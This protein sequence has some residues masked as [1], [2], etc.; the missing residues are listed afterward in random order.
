[1]GQPGKAAGLGEAPEQLYHGMG[2]SSPGTVHPERLAAV[3]LPLAMERWGAW[4]SLLL[5]SGCITQ[6]PARP[7][8]LQH[9]HGHHGSSF[10]P[11]CDGDGL[12]L[13]EFV[14]K[15]ELAIHLV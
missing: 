10:L 13:T 7:G 5:S 12:C 15:S 11:H 4:V 8:P 1:M 14:E 6:R 2:D 9:P 3:A